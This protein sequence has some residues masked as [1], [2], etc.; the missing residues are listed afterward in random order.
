MT[1]PDQREV[2]ERLIARELPDGYYAEIT[3][4]D[5]RGRFRL[6]RW[7]NKDPEIVG[8]MVFPSNDGRTIRLEALVAGERDGN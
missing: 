2:I 1:P 6:G 3:K 4:P 5:E 8:W 7:F